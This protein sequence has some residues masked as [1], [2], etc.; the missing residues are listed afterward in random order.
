MTGAGPIRLLAVAA[1][2]AGC[3]G[4]ARTDGTTEVALA[5]AAGSELRFEPATIHAPAS[6][7]VRVR[8][9]NGSDVAH[10]LTFLSPRTERSRAIVEPGGTEVVAFPALLAGEH[11]FTCTIH[12][13]M[14]GVLIIE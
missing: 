4:D 2:V 6:R 7:P 3:F 9:A 10:N 14:D 12:L 5:T 13:D 8:F 11:R 1:L